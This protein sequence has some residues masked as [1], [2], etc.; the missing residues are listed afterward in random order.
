MGSFGGWVRFYFYGSEIPDPDMK[1]RS[2]N[3]VEEG[4]LIT[5]SS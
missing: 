4:A 5:T 2:K 1:G 3:P